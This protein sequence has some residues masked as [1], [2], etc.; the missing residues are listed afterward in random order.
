MTGANF[1]SESNYVGSGTISHPLHS[2]D[3]D[4][5]VGTKLVEQQRMPIDTPGRWCLG[6]SSPPVLTM[7]I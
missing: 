5:D 6:M 1:Q 2:S 4:D 7:T 3:D